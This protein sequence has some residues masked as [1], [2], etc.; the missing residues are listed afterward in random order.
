MSAVVEEV[1]RPCEGADCGRSVTLKYGRFCDPCRANR[2]R[3]RKLYV[4]NDFIDQRLK[5]AYLK[6]DRKR[7]GDQSVKK[8]AAQIG[9]PVWALRKRAAALGLSRVKESRW[10]DKEFAILE[11]NAWMSPNRIRLK[12]KAAGFARTATAIDIMLDRRMARH[13]TPF[14][15]GRGVALLFG[16]DSHCVTRWIN[17]GYLKAARRGTERHEANG[18]D[19]YQIH[20]NDV[21]TFVFTRPLEFDIRKVDQLWFLDLVTDGKI[22]G[23]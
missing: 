23:V 5:T 13:S 2:R 11:R 10:S 16:V 4:S 18:G 20:E 15:T 22:A 3:K 14:L 1:G 12:L 6:P 17:L 7:S 21:R 9:W 19:M 8:L